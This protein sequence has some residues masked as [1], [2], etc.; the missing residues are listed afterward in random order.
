MPSDYAQQIATI[1]ERTG[2]LVN[3]V[4]EIKDQL[5]LAN[6]R[7]RKDHDK[8]IGLETRMGQWA[9]AQALWTAAAGVFAGWF[10]S[11]R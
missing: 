11:Q 7:Q 1:F 9:T 6:G 4:A 8:I 10:G 5:E 3:D 2:T